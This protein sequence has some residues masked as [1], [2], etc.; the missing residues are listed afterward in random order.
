MRD[1][2]LADYRWLYENTNYMMDGTKCARDAMP[3]LRQKCIPGMSLLDIGSGRGHLLEWWKR[4]GGTGDNYEPATDN[5]DETV[6][7]RHY[8]I[9]TCFDVVEHLTEQDARQ[10]LWRAWA[11][12]LDCLV[13]T[14]CWEPD[15]ATVKNGERVRLHITL[16]EPE[17]WRHQLHVLG[18]SDEQIIDRPC[19]EKTRRLFIVRKDP[20]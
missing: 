20:L 15:I 5:Q 3:F 12:A 18:I 6:E 14:C 2:T 19:R 11:L 7:L 1:A 4:Q 13:F 16:Q 8:D 10:L 17:W 9:V